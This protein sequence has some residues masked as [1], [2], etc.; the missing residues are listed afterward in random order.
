M[1]MDKRLDGVS[2]RGVRKSMREFFGRVVVVSLLCLTAVATSAS[3]EEPTGFLEWS[4][5]TPRATLES[6]FL[7][8]RCKNRTSEPAEPAVCGSY[9]LADIEILSLRLNFK[10]DDALSG[11]VMYFQKEWYAKML[12]AA[13]AKFGGTIQGT[14]W[15]WPS[16]TTALLLERCGGRASGQSSVEQQL[17]DRTTF[18][19]DSFP[20]LIVATQALR[21][22]QSKEVERKR[23]ERKKGF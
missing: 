11:Y 1:L 13:T 20:C 10:P 9:Q 3:A 14:V 21:D 7:L 22:W 12:D 18:I 17:E 6:K 5:G 8:P 16:G 2:E 15:Q 23:E 19:Y 4:W